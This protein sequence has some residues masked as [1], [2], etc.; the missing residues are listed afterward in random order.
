M[1]GVIKRIGYWKAEDF[2]KLIYPTFECIL[3]GLLPDEHYK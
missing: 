1:V 2:Q 3:G